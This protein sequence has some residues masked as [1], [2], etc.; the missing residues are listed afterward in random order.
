MACP[1]TSFYQFCKMSIFDNSAPNKYFSKNWNL[2]KKNPD[3]K[4]N[5]LLPF[6]IGGRLIELDWGYRLIWHVIN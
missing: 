3:S 1:K 5:T 2:R 6:W 4:A